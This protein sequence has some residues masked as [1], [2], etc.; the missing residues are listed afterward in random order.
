MKLIIG[1]EYQGKRDYVKQ[2]FGIREEEIWDC[3]PDGPPEETA[4]CYDHYENYVLYCMRRGIGDCRKVP[5]GKIILMTDV[6]CGVVP[7]DREQRAFRE[8]CGR[9]MTYLAGQAD[10]VVRVFAGLPLRLK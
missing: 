6:F 8:E 5:E 1:G 10:T 2:T 4:V 3:T 7:M 9:V